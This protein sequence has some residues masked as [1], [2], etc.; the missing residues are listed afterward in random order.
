MKVIVWKSYGCISVINADKVGSLLK[1][2]D[3]ILSITKSWGIKELDKI[4]IDAQLL[5]NAS[6]RFGSTITIQ[7][8]KQIINKLLEYTEGDDSFESFEFVTVKE[9][10]Y[11]I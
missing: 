10:E 3:E 1:V 6:Q 9:K 7:E 4:Y 5:L 11:G 8:C 2:I